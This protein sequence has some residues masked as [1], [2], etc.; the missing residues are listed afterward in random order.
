MIFKRDLLTPSRFFGGRLMM[1]P[2]MIRVWA[3]I[4]GFLD[5][6]NIEVYYATEYHLKSA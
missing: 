1:V 4:R 5:V 3:D 6:S 2:N